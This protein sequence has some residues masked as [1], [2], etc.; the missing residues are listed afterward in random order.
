MKDDF[1]RD[2]EIEVLKHKKTSSYSKMW[3]IEIFLVSLLLCFAFAV[4][5][6]I[7]LLNANLAWA[8]FLVLILIFVSAVFDII[9]VAV[10]ASSIKPF[11]ELKQ[12]PKQKGV[13]TAIWFV[14]H[15]DKISSICTDV[16]G[17]ICSIVSGASGM[18]ISL[19]L[20]KEFSGISSVILSIVVS[21]VIAALTVL[22]K[23]L[24]KTFAINNPTKILLFVGKLFEIFLHKNKKKLK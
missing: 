20:I 18:A 3:Y 9:G 14:K 24:G 15:A 11:L 21:S 2:I 23:A 19:I 1:N 8:L 13:S 16:V 7:M 6:Q 10:T 22:A 12:N 5:S 17:D 4:F